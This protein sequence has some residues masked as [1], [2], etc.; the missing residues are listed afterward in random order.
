MVILVFHFLQIVAHP[1]SQMQLNNVLYKENI[2]NMCFRMCLNSWPKRPF[3]IKMAYLFKHTVLLPILAL[4][5]VLLPSSTVSEY[6]QIPIVKFLSH[7]GSFVV[8]LLLLTISSFQDKFD[9]SVQTPSIV[10][11]ISDLLWGRNL[12]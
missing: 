6:M 4:I 7:M 12:P 8:F 9:E 2:S 11:R 3:A 10:G 5:Y 1:Y